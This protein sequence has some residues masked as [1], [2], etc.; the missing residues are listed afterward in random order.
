M[1]TRT[2]ETEENTVVYRSPDWIL[3]SLKGKWASSGEERTAFETDWIIIDFHEFFED[4]LW[5][6]VNFVHVFIK[7]RERQFKNYIIQFWDKFEKSRSFSRLLLIY[8]YSKQF[9]FCFIQAISFKI[10]LE[11]APM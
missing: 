9:F 6:G 7:Q 4:F 2:L 10:H 8:L 5:V 3:G 1:D 11:S